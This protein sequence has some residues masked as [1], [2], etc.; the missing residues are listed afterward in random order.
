MTFL[1][2]LFQQ[3]QVK[4]NSLR[5]RLQQNFILDHVLFGNQQIATRTHPMLAGEP[6]TLQHEIILRLTN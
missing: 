3:P 6:I 1:R 4:V 5:K 2:T